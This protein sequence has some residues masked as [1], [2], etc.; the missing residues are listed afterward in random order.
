MS[1]REKFA[2]R[3][4]PETRERL[5]HCY[6]MDGSLSRRE[7]IENAIQF[8]T[9]Y[10]EMNDGKSLLPK[11]ISAVIDG[12]LGMFEDRMAALIF[13]LAVE[14]DMGISTL[15]DSVNLD[16]EYLRRQR[17]R[18]IANVKSTNGLI[19]LEQRARDTGD[20]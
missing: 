16:E 3:L 18:S 9:D 17:A 6:T 15:A 13:K 2:I 5:E 1:T 8:Y 4:E 19:S 10:L 12:R 7:Y 14:V 20:V 11:E